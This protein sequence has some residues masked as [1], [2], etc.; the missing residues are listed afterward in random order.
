M[1]K[2]IK[3]AEFVSGFNYEDDYYEIFANPT[4]N[5][6]YNIRQQ[7]QP[8]PSIRGVIYDDGYFMAWAGTIMHDKISTKVSISLNGMRFACYPNS[9]VID[10][11]GQYNN[12]TEIAEKIVEHK[13]ILSKIGN[14]NNHFNIYI[15]GMGSEYIHDL[16]FNS[17][18]EDVKEYE[19]NKSAKINI[20]NKRLIKKSNYYDTFKYNGNAIEVFINPTSNEIRDVKNSN[21]F[22]SIRGVIYEDGTLII[23]SGEVIHD[24]VKSDIRVDGSVLR[25]AYESTFSD[26]WFV[27]ANN[28]YDFDELIITLKKYKSVLSKIGDINQPFEFD[29]MVGEIED[30]SGIKLSDYDNQG[31]KVANNTKKLIKKSEFFTSFK[32]N[33]NYYEVFKNPTSDEIQIIKNKCNNSLRGVIYNNDEY[34]IWPDDILH[35]RINNFLKDENIDITSGLTFVYDGNLNAWM[36]DSK[37]RWDPRELTNKIKQHESTLRKIGPLNGK[38][39]IYNTLKTKKNTDPPYLYFDKMDEQL[40]QMGF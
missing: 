9:W 38:I 19:L 14:I 5:E 33:N 31:E 28:S 23:W 39:S 18:I 36:F 8:Y 20:I 12:F 3:K 16:N 11:G 30:A 1:N 29:F 21:D 35:D 2:L 40:D 17:I 37:G 4:V 34:I 26:P 25:F 15:N 24:E 32:K 27:D 13:N 10:G 7:S 6:L 22:K